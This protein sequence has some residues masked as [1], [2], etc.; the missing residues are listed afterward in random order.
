MEQTRNGHAPS[1]RLPESA[2]AV[3]CSA[4][5]LTIGS[6]LR[7]NLSTDKKL[8]RIRVSSGAIYLALDAPNETM[9]R[10]AVV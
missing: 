4:L 6:G 2:Y 10:Q 9:D 8:F 5:P 7:V 3:T 1:S